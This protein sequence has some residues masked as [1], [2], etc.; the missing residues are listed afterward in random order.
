MEHGVKLTGKE[1][2]ATS[3]YLVQHQEIKDINC[4]LQQRV[5]DASILGFQSPNLKEN[6]KKVFCSNDQIC[7]IFYDIFKLK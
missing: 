4:A 7:D 1:T 6:F 2:D 3:R 5:G